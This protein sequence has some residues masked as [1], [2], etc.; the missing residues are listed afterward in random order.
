MFNKSEEKRLET[1]KEQASKKTTT[2]T[3]K[4]DTP[5]K[6]TIVTENVDNTKGNAEHPIMEDYMG[7]LRRSL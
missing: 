7:E 6:A 5:K 3:Q 2:K 1:L 4:I